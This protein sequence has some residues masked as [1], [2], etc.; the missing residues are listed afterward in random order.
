M[1]PTIYPAY[2]PSLTPE[3]EEYIV[4]FTKDW[5]IAHGLAVR[6][7]PTALGDAATK[8]SDNA[9]LGNGALSLATTA[10]VTLFPSLFPMQCFHEALILQKAYNEVYSAIARDEK[11]L[12][13]MVEE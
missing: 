10:P 6:P 4:T 7:N 11:W 1:S 8:S 5:S 3:Q 2:P 13:E 12:A 9:L